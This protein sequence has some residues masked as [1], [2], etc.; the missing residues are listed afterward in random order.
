MPCTSLKPFIPN[1]H[2]LTNKQCICAYTSI[3]LI[4][5]LGQ[6]QLSTAS[7]QLTHSTNQWKNCQQT[8]QEC[9]ALSTQQNKLLPIDRTNTYD[10]WS[11][12]DLLLKD[13]GH[14]NPSSVCKVTEQ[15]P[16]ALGDTGIQ[17]IEKSISFKGVAL[18]LPEWALFFTRW[19]K[20]GS[21]W[22]IADVEMTLAHK[23][24]PQWVDG[25]E[26][27]AQQAS[28]GEVPLYT[29]VP[30]YRMRLQCVKYILENQ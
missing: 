14:D 18:S 5:S 11:L 26:I 12:L 22:I 29:M 19:R 4:F 8:L 25:K 20:A 30:R 27:A 28:K 21:P 9:G 17:K 3:L 6:C 23:P 15:A 2:W 16:F 10:L 24:L 7:A 13:M 1:T